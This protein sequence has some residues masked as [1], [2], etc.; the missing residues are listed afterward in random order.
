MKKTMR[1]VSLFLVAFIVMGL[2]AACSSSGNDPKTSPS[3]DKTGSEPA[4][5]SEP[6][7]E[8]KPYN[9]HVITSRAMDDK[10]DYGYVFGRVLKDYVAENP[11]YT[12]DY[13]VVEQMD[14]PGKIS[15]LIASNDVPDFFTTEA[16]G[17]MQNIIQSGGIANM[18]EAVKEL[19]FNYDDIVADGA[20]GGMNVINGRP[21]YYLPTRYAISGVWYNKEIFA[22]NNIK[23]PETWEEFEAVCE[24][25]KA[26]G[27]QP[28]VA[29]GAG[30]WPVTRWV[31]LAMTRML[32]H[33][34]VI[35]AS[36]MKNGVT[37]RDEG[38]AEATGYMQRLFQKGYFGEGWNSIDVSTSINM[39]LTG[40]TAMIYYTGTIVASL[41]NPEINKIG[42]DAIGVFNMPNMEASKTKEDGRKMAIVNPGQALCFGKTKFE[43]GTNHGVLKALVSNIG[44][45]LW[46][47]GAI[48][49]YKVE[50][51][52]GFPPLMNDIM[53]Y[54]NT[55]E[56]QLTWFEGNMST[57]VT[58]KAFQEGQL[59]S[60]GA[61]TPEQFCEIIAA[62]IEEDL[63]K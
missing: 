35:N 53:D 37:F 31:V 8:G 43:E 3:V 44:Q 4:K 56:Y 39:F 9:I 32:G 6:A 33:D 47:L 58:T 22:A 51:P 26:A 7:P 49:P 11:N 2:F 17:A 21:Y 10:G 30:Q 50:M 62:A 15:L 18:E 63:K 57:A 52:D 27:I 14:I 40:K 42:T 36:T 19:G 48:S 29:G 38:Y 13:E 46:E 54:Y 23:I 12:Y 16:G 60:E 1:L 20:K 24:K 25:L 45:Y 34:A 61:I 55:M 59:L 28:M 41:M 5:S